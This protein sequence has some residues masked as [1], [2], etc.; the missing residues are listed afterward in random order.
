MRWDKV[1]EDFE[2]WWAGELERPLIQMR[3]TGRDPGRLPPRHPDHHRTAFYDFSIPAEEVVDV[4]DYRLSGMEFLGDRFP[5]VMPDFG[6]GKLLNYLG[7]I[8]QLGALVDILGSA[9]GVVMFTGRDISERDRMVELLQ[10]Y[11]VQ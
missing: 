5:G 9:E 2:H 6:P 4:W 10:L 1:K 7:S 3:L 8:D 11:G